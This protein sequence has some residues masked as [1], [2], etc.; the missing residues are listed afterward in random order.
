MRDDEQVLLSTEPDGWR[1]YGCESHMGDLLFYDLVAPDSV[2]TS[3]YVNLYE[4]GGDYELV[5]AQRP[6]EKP[7]DPTKDDPATDWRFIYH[8]E[9]GRWGR[10]LLEAR[11]GD[12]V[13]VTLTEGDVHPTLR[14]LWWFVHTCLPRLDVL[15]RPD[16]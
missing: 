4:V 3:I 6:F 7:Y 2:E 10:E 16:V 8:C 5:S 13:E 14:A 1:L 12:E 15:G 11:I 9:T